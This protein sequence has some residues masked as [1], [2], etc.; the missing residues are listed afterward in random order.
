MC[1]ALAPYPDL[2][3]STR[4]RITQSMSVVENLPIDIPSDH[5]LDEAILSDM[6]AL[7]W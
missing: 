1:R 3:N 4:E 7:G 6:T 2:V 5:I